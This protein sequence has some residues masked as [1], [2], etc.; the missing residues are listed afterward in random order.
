MA[1]LRKGYAF[2]WLFVMVDA[3]D[4]ATPKTG[5]SPSVYY[6]QDGAAFQAIAG[7]SV[8]ELGNG[9]FAYTLTAAQATADTLILLA[10]A[11]G[12][13]QADQVFYLKPILQNTSWVYAFKLCDETDFATPETGVSPSAYAGLDGGALAACT[14]AD[15]TEIGYGWYYVTLAA[16]ETN[17]DVIAMRATGTG[18]A[19]HLNAMYLPTSVNAVDLIGSVKAVLDAAV[20]GGTIPGHWYGDVPVGES[21]PYIMWQLLG[22]SPD[23]GMGTAALRA[24]ETDEYRLSFNVWHKGAAS[25]DVAQAIWNYIE[26]IRTVLDAKPC[27]ISVTNANVTRCHEAGMAGVM[28]DRGPGQD[29]SQWWRGSIDYEIRVQQEA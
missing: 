29:D 12:C 2:T 18:C 16:A 7:A 1:Q 17:G 21:S 4:F 25:G 28:R 24:D 23:D 15:E 9:L 11:P 27:P 3:S 8:S 22:G 20:I 26:A 13:A 19:D 6:S 10:T 5:V 14:N